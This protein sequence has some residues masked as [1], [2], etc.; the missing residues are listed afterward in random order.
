MRSH[1]PSTNHE[2]TIMKSE[3]SVNKKTGEES[4]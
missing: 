4:F 1:I 2:L 3:N